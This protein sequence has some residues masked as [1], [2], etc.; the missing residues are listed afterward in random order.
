MALPR[1]VTPVSGERPKTI[2]DQQEI[3]ELRL[4]WDM[5]CGATIW[6]PR[7]SAI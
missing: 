5:R 3:G 6:S 4:A 2:A 1:D 7:S